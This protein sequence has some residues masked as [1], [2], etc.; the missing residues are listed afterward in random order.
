M[1]RD[2]YHYDGRGDTVA[3]TDDAGNVTDTKEFDAWG[4]II[5]STGSTVTPYQFG[6]SQGYQTG[7]NGVYVR[8]RVYQSIIS[9]W[10]SQD[11]LGPSAS[12]NL[13]RVVDN[14]PLILMDPSGLIQTNANVSGLGCADLSHVEETALMTCGLAKTPCSCGVQNVAH[15]FAVPG[16]IAAILCRGGE[17]TPSINLGYLFG[18]QGAIEQQV[19]IEE[20]KNAGILDCIYGHEMH[21]VAQYNCFCPAVCRGVPDGFGVTMTVGCHDIA[22]CWGWVGQLNCMIK[23]AC[24]AFDKKETERFDYIKEKIAAWVPIAR[25]HCAGAGLG[26]REDLVKNK[27]N[28]DR[29][30]KGQPCIP[31]SGI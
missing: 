9:R 17:P 4:N 2:Y 28:F 14:C 16:N 1:S 19:H 30:L 8:A 20:L 13:Y 12:R 5:A 22:E 26:Q 15:P 31:R 7:N 6:G 27:A 29:L 24:A 11:P 25:K 18:E 10:M 21:H 3:L 23:K